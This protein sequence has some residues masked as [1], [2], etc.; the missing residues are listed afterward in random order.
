MNSGNSS[1]SYQLNASELMEAARAETGLSDFGDE[2]F[3]APF[4]HL[5]SRI[6]NEIRFKPDGLE[7]I[8]TAFHRFLVNRLRMQ[9]DITAHPEILDEQIVKPIII[10]GFPRS[11][12][13]KLQRMISAAPDV[14]KLRTWQMLNP[15]PFPESESAK[16]DVRRVTVQSGGVGSTDVQDF[17]DLMAGHYMDLEVVEEEVL[18]MDHSLDPSVAGL[19]SYVPLLFH[20]DWLEGVE[21]READIK[22]YQFLH[23]QI[24]YLQWQNKADPSQPWIMKCPAHTQHLPALIETFPDATLVQSHRDPMVVMPSIAKLMT[25]LWSVNV[26]VDA[27]ASGYEFYEQLVMGMERCLKARKEL[28]L[29]GRIID[30]RYSDVRSNA[31]SVIEEIYQRSGRELTAEAKAAMQQW[32]DENEQGKHGRHSYS[33]AEFGLDEATIKSELAEYIELFH[34]YF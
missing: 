24:Q 16:F 21:L 6:E 9:A 4:E 20:N 26:E 15:A 11:G 14:Q 27:K 19:C 12:T 33:L 31:M 10:L 32:E 23:T 7:N 3:I 34:D 17:E 30:V 29:D 13:T 5:L 22:G 8:K 2:S 18:L 28:Q 1:T 25:N